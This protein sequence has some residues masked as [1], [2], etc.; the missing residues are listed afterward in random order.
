M[1]IAADNEVSNAYMRAL[2]NLHEK[3]VPRRLHRRLFP[4]YPRRPP[5][6]LRSRF[7]SLLCHNPIQNENHGQEHNHTSKNFIYTAARK[8]NEPT[9]K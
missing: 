6:P 3:T 7:F 1:S 9:L 2:R 4:L 8:Y 5:Y